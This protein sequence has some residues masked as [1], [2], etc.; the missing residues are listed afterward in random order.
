MSAECPFSSKNPVAQLERDRV[1]GAGWFNWPAS[2]AG[3]R[4]R[5]ATVRSR[6][7]SVVIRHHRHAGRDREMVTQHSPEAVPVAVGELLVHRGL[8]IRELLAE[9]T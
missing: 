2:A 9:E 6:R 1:K 4:R 5:S 8:S 7:L 3:S